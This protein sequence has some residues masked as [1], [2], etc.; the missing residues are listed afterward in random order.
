MSLPASD[1]RLLAGGRADADRADQVTVAR[2]G[3]SV[4][5]A[6]KRLTPIGRPCGGVEAELGRVPDRGVCAA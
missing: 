6:C 1:G 5:L 3:H 2:A 4:G